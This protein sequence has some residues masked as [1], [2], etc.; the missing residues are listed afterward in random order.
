MLLKILKCLN[1]PSEG[2]GL[3]F[4]KNT[5]WIGVSKILENL[6]S[7]IIMI[8]ITRRLGAEGLGQ[9]S[10]IFA[11]AGIFFIFNDWGLTPLM[12]RDLAK[13]KSKMKEYVSNIF[14]FKLIMLATALI[15]F[16]I[17]L[18]FIGKKELLISLLLSGVLFSLIKFSQ[19]LLNILIVE[20]NGK[21][22]AIGNIT[23]RIITLIIGG[24]VLYNYNKL[25]YFI[26]VL[27]ISQ[28]I[29]NIILYKSI[30][31]KDIFKISKEFKKLKV[32][33]KQGTPLLL[34]GVFTTIYVHIDTVILSYLKGDLITGFYNGPYK[35]INVTNIIPMTMLTF[36]FPLISKIISKDN[37][38]TKQIL[39]KII[40]ASMIILIP[41]VVVVLF[42]S[43]EILK[44]VYNI[45]S[46]DSSNIFKILIFTCIFIHL[47]TILGQF[48]IAANKQNIF[49]KIAC[50]G[51]IIN[52]ILNFLL[53]PNFSLYGA[54]IS[55]LITYFIMFILMSY[56]VRY[57]IVY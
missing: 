25:S 19:F 49:S 53:I 5:S 14:T 31:S 1:L 3:E 20:N 13:D 45:S 6:L 51:A 30:S 37:K 12:V 24:I 56:Y 21:N 35:L 28:I 17:S 50:F 27:L 44:I 43:G 34:I 48:I 38:K 2:L 15:I 22:I 39:K 10:F 36:G 46:L 55:T 11:F 32:L 4:I 29:K 33:I 18:F 57:K 16:T 42:F 23:E 9:Y 52:I 40:I 41:I 8:L 54:G 47:T 7:F 26:I